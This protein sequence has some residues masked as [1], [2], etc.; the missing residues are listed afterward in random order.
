MEVGTCGGSFQGINGKPASLRVL[1]VVWVGT[2]WVGG[3]GGFGLL[4]LP[5][6]PSLSHVRS[7]FTFTFHLHPF[8]FSSLLPSYPVP[9]TL[10][11]F[12][13]L[14]FA[15][16]TPPRPH[17]FT[18]GLASQGK[19][20]TPASLRAFVG[21]SGLGWGWCGL[22]PDFQKMLDGRKVAQIVRGTEGFVVVIAPDGIGPLLDPPDSAGFAPALPQFPG[23]PPPTDPAENER[24]KKTLA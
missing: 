8:S 10:P 6:H 3:F 24:R 4:Y 2:E 11:L 1:W 17:Y 19:G 18:E 7:S 22:G 16:P 13:L 14:P 9:F 15:F 5:F 20:G 23:P 12:P 21:G